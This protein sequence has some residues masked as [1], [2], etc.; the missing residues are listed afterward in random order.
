MHSW[1]C[2][3][4]GLEARRGALLGALPMK[5][6]RSSF[7][8]GTYNFARFALFLLVEKCLEEWQIND[9]FPERR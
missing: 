3:Y 7:E 2:L 4:N 9:F 6:S 8:S 1:P 5:K